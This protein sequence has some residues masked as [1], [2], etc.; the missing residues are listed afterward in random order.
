MRIYVDIDDVLCET[1]ATLCTIAARDFDRHVAYDAVREFDLQKVFSLTDAE[2]RCFSVISHSPD[3]L[4]SYPVT[5]GAVDGVRTLRAAGHTVDFVTGRPASSHA[6]T[7]AWLAAAGLSGFDVT[8]VDKYGRTDRYAARPDDPPT[9]T[10]DA[11]TARRYDVAIDDSP[12]ALE[13]LAAWTHTRVLVFDRPWNRAFPLAPNMRRIDGWH[14]LSAI[15][16]CPPP[17]TA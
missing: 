13:R 11:L 1:A 8:Y 6:G 16:P 4:A 9:V 3:V 17:G 14:D 5:S 10:M 2:M 12:V 7:E 15:R